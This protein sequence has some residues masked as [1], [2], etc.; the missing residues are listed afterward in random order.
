MD[1]FEIGLILLAA[2]FIILLAL[3]V[4]AAVVGTNI[5]DNCGIIENKS[6]CETRYQYIM[7][8]KI[9]SVQ[10]YTVCDEYLMCLNGTKTEWSMI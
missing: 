3:V 5:P 1:A 10:P 7:V 2:I 6:H 4:A 9:M 8:G